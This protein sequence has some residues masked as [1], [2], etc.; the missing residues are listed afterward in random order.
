M[1]ARTAAISILFFILL[2]GTS[3][4]SREAPEDETS[5][6]MVSSAP[7]ADPNDQSKEWDNWQKSPHAKTYDLGKGPNTYCAQCHAPRNWDPQ[8]VIDPPPNCVSCKFAFEDE[9]RVAAGNP[10]VP[11]EEW[12]D[13]RCDVCHQVS[14]GVADPLPLWWDQAAGQYVPVASA[15]EQCEKCHTDT[16]TILHQRDMGSEAH[17]DFECTECHDAHSVAASCS[18]EVCHTAVSTDNLA[19]DGDMATAAAEAATAMH[20]A[21]HTAVDCVACHDTSG[22]EVGPLEE[23]GRWTTWR[24]TELMERSS[25]KPYQSHATGLEVDCR[26]CHFEGNPWQL[27]L[28]E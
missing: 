2:V 3:C 7:T 16:E 6:P 20:G 8:A 17:K 5:A 22:L 12:V 14:E 28:V 10:L 13:I 21:E 15:T 11:V 25:T 19:E 1:N 9:P 4:Q 18:N 27:G 23:N 24:T 26:R